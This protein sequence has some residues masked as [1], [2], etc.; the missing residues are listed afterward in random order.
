MCKLIDKFFSQVFLYY[1]RALL[2][3]TY[4]RNM[5]KIFLI[6]K[7]RTTN[8]GNEA[9]SHEIIKM[10]TQQLNDVVININGRP[11]GLEGY[12]PTK[13]FKSPDP[14]TTFEHWTD[15]IV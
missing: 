4:R 1:F 6:T 12:L 2:K 15:K 3:Y 8:I 14:I 13:L 9:L 10:F 11:S 5:K 7:L